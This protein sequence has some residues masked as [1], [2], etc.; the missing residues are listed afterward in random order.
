MAVTIRGTWFVSAIF[1]NKMAVHVHVVVPESD[2]GCRNLLIVA[3][4]RRRSG[5]IMLATVCDIARPTRYYQ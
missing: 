3:L 5:C 2:N 1:I 4:G